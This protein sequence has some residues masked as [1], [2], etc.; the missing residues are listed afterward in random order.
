MTAQGLWTTFSV[1]REFIGSCL[2]SEDGFQA[3]DAEEN[4][5]ATPKNAEDAERI[6][7]GCWEAK[8]RSNGGTQHKSEELA[9]EVDRAQLEAF[10]RT[11]FKHATAGNWISLRVF[12]E[13]R[14]DLAPFRITPVKLNGNLGTLVD[15]AYHNA[16]LAASA[17]TKV[18]FCPPIATFTGKK[19]AREQNLAE[20]PVLSIECDSHP[21]AALARLKALLG[22][23]TVVVESGGVWTNL[24]TG[25]TEPKLHIYYCLSR[26]ARTK[27][28]QGKLK[29][30]R[31]LATG[32]VGGDP[33]NI[34]VV[35]P[36]R[37]PGSLH[38]KGDTKLCKIIELNACV[39][40]DL[41][42]TLQILQTTADKDGI[43]VSQQQKLHFNGQKIAP[44]F[45]HLDAS[46]GLGAGIEGPPPLAFDLIK[47]GCGW[48][49]EAYET[50]G[51]DHDNP[52]WHLMILA[53]TFLENGH[54]LA[55]RLGNKH[56]KYTR[57]ETEKKWA[58]KIRERA[59]NPNLG[60]P[61]CKAICDNG[62]SRHCKTCPHLA[63]G[64]SPLNLGLQKPFEPQLDSDLPDLVIGHEPTA[65]AKELAKLIAQADHYFFNGHAPVRIAVE[66]NNMPRAI[67]VTAENVRVLAHEISNPIRHTKQGF[68]LKSGP[69][70][71]TSI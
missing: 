60:W 61:S 29:Q 68:P 27:D 3:F 69:T 41:D 44:A 65:V 46:I 23:P 20:G 64:K 19:D 40:I 11:L 63:L 24:E 9:P 45:A 37:W 42:H 54:E 51:K 8:L 59:N 17:P 39:E 67:P 62:G 25:E 38:R 13:G 21:R 71:P 47:Q 52:Q 56:H 53:M 1:D 66:V 34:S 12:Y 35:H 43:S 32:L 18:V 10:I 28:E 16:Q 4:F 14:A 7:F 2:A 30:A 33:S 22:P 70:S 58:E 49:R 15:R 5:L 48:L 57:E 6:V 26:P 36:I 55:H 31:R 50:G